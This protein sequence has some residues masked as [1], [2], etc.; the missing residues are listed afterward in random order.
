[1]PFLYALYAVV[2]FQIIFVWVLTFR[3]S[4]VQLKSF[5]EFRENVI[6]NGIATVLLFLS[7]GLVLSGLSFSVAGK[8]ILVFGG[9]LFG[10]VSWLGPLISPFFGF[11]FCRE[12]YLARW[13]RGLRDESLP[14]GLRYGVHSESSSSGTSSMMQ[15]RLRRSAV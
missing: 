8:C 14:S 1:M 13:K 11:C 7:F 2:L 5:N 9:T 15:A 10:I 6:S 4:R 12:Q 3:V